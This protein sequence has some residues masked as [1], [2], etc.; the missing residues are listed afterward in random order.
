MKFSFEEEVL[1][2][3]KWAP[4][5]EGTYGEWEC[6]FE[7]WIDLYDATEEKIKGITLEDLD[8]SL[9]RDLLYVLGRDNECERVREFL[10]N[11][12]ALLRV[13]ANRAIAL[14]DADARWQLAKSIGESNF[15]DGADLLRP[16]LC[17]ADEYVRRQSLM[18]ITPLA[19]AEAEEI[20][21][22]NMDDDFE[23]SRIVGLHVL[24]EV[25]S[26]ALDYFLDRHEND[27][28]EHVRKRVIEIQ[29]KKEKSGSGGIG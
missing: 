5:H 15:K 22:N 28:S 14:G 29:N 2:F 19:P 11:Y 26:E 23:Y 4:R 6:D 20:A 18:A 24:N 25:N 16:Y 17:D 10:M 3:R 9:L 1:R 21:K 8:E 7:H 13:L 12:P 27:P